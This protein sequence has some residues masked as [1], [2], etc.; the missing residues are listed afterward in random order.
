LLDEADTDLALEEE[1]EEAARLRRMA[2][3]AAGDDTGYVM[4][5]VTARPKG[6]VLSLAALERRAEME[7]A[8]TQGKGKGKGKGGEGVGVGMS[9]PILGRKEEIAGVIAAHRVT[10]IEGESE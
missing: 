9:L 8:K 1:R 3:E 10:I 2:E 4:P 7:R 5:A 6:A